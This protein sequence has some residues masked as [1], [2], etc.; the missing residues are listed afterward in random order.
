MN[1]VRSSISKFYIT[2]PSNASMTLYPNNKVNDYTTHLAQDVYFDGKWEVNLEEIT[3]PYNWKEEAKDD[4]STP[5]L[6]LY[7]D[8]VEAQLVG[9]TKVSLLRTVPI[10]GQRNSIINHEFKRDHYVTLAGSGYKRDIRI[11][12][13]NDVGESVKFESGKL[14]CVLHFR[15]CKDQ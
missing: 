11:K 9:E 1:E 4:N 6:Y 7:C 3:F 10:I 5:S 15:R 2:L 14:V 13:C 12:T 8:W